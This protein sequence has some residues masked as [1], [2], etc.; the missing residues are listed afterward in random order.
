MTI[1]I[2]MIIVCNLKYNHYN[3]LYCNT[4]IH[5]FEYIYDIKLVLNEHSRAR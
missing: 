2:I 4:Y 3:N 1:M 5:T